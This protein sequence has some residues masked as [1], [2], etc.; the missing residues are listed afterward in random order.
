MTATGGQAGPVKFMDC[1]RFCKFSQPAKRHRHNPASGGA[2]R[3]AGFTL[4]ELF[5][6]L[7]V[8]AFLVTV[9]APSLQATLHDNRLMTQ[10]N[11][12][13]G[14][15]NLARSEAIKR[16]CRVTLCKT[17]DQQQCTT[18]GGYQQGWLVF[19]DTHNFAAVDADE[20][21][22][23]TFAPVTGGLTITG[24]SSV[25]DYVS[26]A[27]N[28]ASRLINGGFQAGSITLCQDSAARRIIINATGRVRSTRE[29][30]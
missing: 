19:A 5:I 23:Q 22:I 6:T 3:A 8:L 4:L 26:Y 21:I 29:S 1:Y 16:G 15:L 7:A 18:A 11:L 14:A 2:S 24:N 25:Q 28:G 9:A 27:A 30:C 10:T 13:I 20:T 12:F 17:S